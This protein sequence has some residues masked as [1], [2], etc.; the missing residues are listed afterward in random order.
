M[1]AVDHNILVVEDDSVL[2]NAMSDLLCEE[3]IPATC[4]E[5][6]QVGL[7][8]LRAGARPCLVLLDLQMPLVDGLTFR[9]RQ[10]EDPR[11]AGIPVVVMTGQPGRDG[12]AQTL[13]VSL[14][15]KK[16]VAPSRVLGVVEQYC[17]HAK[18]S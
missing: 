1:S 10:L 2:R 14:Y 11:F 6:G 18:A 15:M 7:D 16:P 5:N 17:A 12:E 3:G 4:A 8:L 13:G 9:R